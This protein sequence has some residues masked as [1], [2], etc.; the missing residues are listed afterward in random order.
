MKRLFRRKNKYSD[1]NQKIYGPPPSWINKSE[2]YGPPLKFDK[3]DKI[4]PKI[5]GTEKE[6]KDD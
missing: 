2:L 1:P 6:K 5:V 3:E 4:D